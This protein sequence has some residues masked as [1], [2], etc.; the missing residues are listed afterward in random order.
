MP[1]GLA[2]PGKEAQGSAGASPG[3]LPAA[4]PGVNGGR[5]GLNAAQ[6]MQKEVG[7]PRRRDTKGGS[8]ASAGTCVTGGLLGG[9]G[10]GGGAGGGGLAG[11]AR[12]GRG[13][14]LPVRPDLPDLA[15]CPLCVCKLLG[16]LLLQLGNR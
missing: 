11:L 16:Q 8:A 5:S 4:R 7:A 12:G 3:M 14:F 13:H 15:D 1:Q 2:E 10:G 6:W 9:F